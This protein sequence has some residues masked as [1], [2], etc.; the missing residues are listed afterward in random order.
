MICF[1]RNPSKERMFLVVCIINTF[2]IFARLQ[3]APA[4][5]SFTCRRN[6]VESNLFVI[7]WADETVMNIRIHFQFG[8][9]IWFQKLTKYQ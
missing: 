3:I 5:L 2:T 6:T 4:F 1:V 7:N 9:P 8:M